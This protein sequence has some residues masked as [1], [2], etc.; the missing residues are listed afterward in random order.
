MYC[1]QCGSAVV[2][3]AAYCNVCGSPVEKALPN[4]AASKRLTS[5]EKWRLPLSTLVTGL[6]AV[7]A[8]LGLLFVLVSRAEG[9]TGQGAATAEGDFA[10]ET[11]TFATPEDAVRYFYEALVANDFGM[12][13][14]ACAVREQ[15]EGYDFLGWVDRLKTHMPLVHMAPSTGAMF[16]DMNDAAAAGTF[17]GQIKF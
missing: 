16:R 6:V 14:E 12:A 17:A 10:K 2:E 7:F 11:P 13:L 5:K 4:A 9:T 8:I 3:D 1:P 15:A